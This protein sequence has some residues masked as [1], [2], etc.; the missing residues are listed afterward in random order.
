MLFKALDIQYLYMYYKVVKSGKKWRPPLN[1]FSGKYYNSLDPKGRV[2]IPASFRNLIQQNYGSKVYVTT[3]AF[4]KCLLVY[5][6]PL[7]YELVDKIRALPQM[8]KSV[9]F[10]MRRV[11]ASAHECELD[12]QGR[13]LIPAPLRR[14]ADIDGEL[15]VVGQIDRIEIWSREE[16]DREVDIDRIDREAYEEELAELGF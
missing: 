3:A 13:L 14:D 10:L 1:G 7:W 6:A 16:W 9:R 11:V 2:M 5:P 12:R 8:K 15:V 4:D